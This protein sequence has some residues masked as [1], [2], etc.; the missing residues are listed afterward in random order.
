[1]GREVDD[2]Y[3]GAV[4]DREVRGHLEEHAPYT[5]E[6]ADSIAVPTIGGFFVGTSTGAMCASRTGPAWDPRV[7]WVGASRACHQSRRR[8]RP[9]R[10]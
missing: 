4:S 9:S 5:A 10:R 8:P 3:P 2:T 1:M 6:G 7:D